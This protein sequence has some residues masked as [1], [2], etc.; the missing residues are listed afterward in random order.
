MSILVINIINAYEYISNKFII[1]IINLIM[2]ITSIQ[3][4][5]K[6]TL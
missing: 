5:K 3:Y 1:M 6:T 4:S 2:Y